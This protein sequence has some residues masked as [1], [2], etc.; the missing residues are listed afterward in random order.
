[1]L[2]FNE[3]YKFCPKCGS[4]T[5]QVKPNL[6]DCTKCGHHI[7]INPVPANAV[8]IK[9]ENDEVLLVER[10]IEPAKGLWDL[11]GGFLELG[12]TVE[13]S[14]IREIKEEL[15][16]TL[17]LTDIKYLDSFSGRYEFSDVNYYTIGM[18]YSANV[19]KEKFDLL[20]VHDDI[21]GHKF[22]SRTKIE[23]KRIAFPVI[24]D[25]LYKYFIAL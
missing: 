4:A 10:A 5:K 12:E 13:E 1:M 23:W 17:E 18:V 24:R 9:N 11:P 19:S 3:V 2:E 16:L 20:Q 22:F 8:I 7:Y 6:F 14:V 25:I 15:G 21:S